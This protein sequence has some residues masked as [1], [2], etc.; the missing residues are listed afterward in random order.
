MSITLIENQLIY[1]FMQKIILNNFLQLKKEQQIN[2]LQKLIIHDY[3]LILLN[4]VLQMSTIQSEALAS[5]IIPS[6]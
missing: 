2:N 3:H 4:F 5:A 1:L 6:T